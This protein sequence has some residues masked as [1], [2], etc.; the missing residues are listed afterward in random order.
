MKVYGCDVAKDFIILHDGKEKYKITD[1]DLELLKEL[2]KESTVV[3]EQTGAYGIRWAYIFEDAGA[4]VYIADGK[5]FKAF[6]HGR[7]RRKDDFIDAYYL[8][9]FFLDK[10]KRK[11]CKPF[12]PTMINLRAIVR[13]HIRNEKDLTRTMNRLMQY[14]AIIFPY[15][16]YYNLKRDKFLK[17]LTEIEAE[18]KNTPHALSML[19]LSELKKLKTTIESQK[20]LEEELKSI[21]RNHPD[22]PILSSFPYFGGDILIA[23]L[24]AYY[25]DIKNF[26][27]V[28]AF[29]GYTLMGAIREQSGTSINKV[30][31]DK[32][33][34]EIKGKFF[35]LFRL[36]HRKNSYYLPLTDILKARVYGGW[37]FKKR[38]IKF[39]SRL[40]EL[41]YYALKHRLHYKEVLKFKISE[42]EKNIERLRSSQLNKIKAFELSRTVENL[43][44]YKEMLKLV[45]CKDISEP[46]EGAEH[47]VYFHQEIFQKE[48]NHEAQ[49]TDNNKTTGRRNRLQREASEGDTGGT[50]R[51]NQERGTQGS[52]DRAKRISHMEAQK[53]KSESEE[54][55]P[56]KEEKQW[57]KLKTETEK[58]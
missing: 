46:M 45:E 18:L 26:P 8:R 52:K 56:S 11:Y 39:L 53:R 19:A 17:S 36:A 33:R 24:I 15:K 9:L 40:F 2:V 23:T 29:I 58:G 4:K 30:K 22:Y 16:E 41:V 48:A 5:E 31:T 21:A 57:N 3:L 6:R 54:P 10:T 51:D 34:T 38:Y 35:N 32:A 12:F 44:I 43:E 55:H 50:H 25:W 27:S 20:L 13:Q 47:Q 28:D 1:E 49:Q 7:D 42:I 14:T 37:N